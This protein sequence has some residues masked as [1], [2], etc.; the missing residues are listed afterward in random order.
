MRKF[1]QK[2]LRKPVGLLAGKFSTRPDKAKIHRSFTQLK[3]NILKQPGKKGLLIPFNA[4]ANFIIF[5][6]QH[7]GAKNGSDIFALAEK[8]YLTALQYYNKENFTFINLG[9]GE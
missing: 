9:D 4:E 6:D 8:N 3:E 7:K 5:S 2:T 1:L